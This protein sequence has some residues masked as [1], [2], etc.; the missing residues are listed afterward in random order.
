MVSPKPPEYKSMDEWYE[1]AQKWYDE[2]KKWYD[3][4]QKSSDSIIQAANAIYDA[5]YWTCDK[6]CGNEEKL[7]EALR[8]ALGRE[9]GT[10][11]GKVGISMGGG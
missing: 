5:G 10:G 2:A 3:D 7:W 9:P 6:E 8:D 4:S 11:P 1:E